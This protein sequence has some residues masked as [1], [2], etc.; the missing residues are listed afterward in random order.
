MRSVFVDGR[1]WFDRVNGN[2]YFAARVFVDGQEVARIPFQYGY[3]SMF[4]SAAAWALQDL[5][6]GDSP[7]LWHV[8]RD[9]GAD[10][11]RS[12]QRVTK[13]ECV[14][15]GTPWADSVI[16]PGRYSRPMTAYSRPMTAADRVAIVTA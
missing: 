8:A 2:T 7:V 9:A 10:L 1:E 6:Y 16:V 4:E 12:V 14:G 5:G 11:Y 15:W 3:G 13:R